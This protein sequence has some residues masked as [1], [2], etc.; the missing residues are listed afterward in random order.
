VRSL[1]FVPRGVDLRENLI[2]ALSEPWGRPI[3]VAKFTCNLLKLNG[4]TSACIRRATGAWPKRLPAQ[5]LFSPAEFA[6][7]CDDRLFRGLLEAT[8]V[9]DIELERFLTATRFTML[10]VAS[11][12]MDSPQLEETALRFFCPLVQQ[13]FTNEYIFAYMDH[14]IEQAERSRALLIEALARISHTK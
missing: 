3:D 12:G 13:C 2:R 10:E 5:E 1:N 4:A 7:V 6:E 8:F 9:C 11:A 14:E